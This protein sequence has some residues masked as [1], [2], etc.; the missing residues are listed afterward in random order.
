LLP[1][2]DYYPLRQ[3][4]ISISH[5]RWFAAPFP[6]NTLAIFTVASLVITSCLVPLGIIDLGPTHVLDA[7]SISLLALSFLFFVQERTAL[8]RILSIAGVASGLAPLFFPV[9]ET[10]ASPEG[11]PIHAHAFIKGHEDPFTLLLIC[12]TAALVSAKPLKSSSKNWIMALGAFSTFLVVANV[13]ILG[14]KVAG[15][16][17]TSELGFAN[18]IRIRSLFCLMTLNFAIGF[19]AF[20]KCQFEGWRQSWVAY[21]VALGVIV[22]TFV[23]CSGQVE[24]ETKNKRA[25]AEA[26]ADAMRAQLHDKIRT[27]SLA[28]RRM[29][30][31]IASDGENDHVRWAK[32]A[33]NYIADNPEFKTI[34]WLDKDRGIRWIEPQHNHSKEFHRLRASE[35]SQK[36]ALDNAIKKGS[37]TISRPFKMASNGLAFT[38]FVPIVANGRFQGVVAST[39]QI[40]TLMQAIPSTFSHGFSYNITEQ[41]EVIFG[42]QF[43]KASNVQ[44]STMLKD[45]DLYWIVHAMPVVQ[46]SPWQTP[47]SYLIIAIGF[48]VAT[49]T[50]LSLSFLEKTS[51]YIKEEEKGRRFL[52]GLSDTSVTPT[53]VYDLKQRRMTYANRFGRETLG[54]SEKEILEG[55]LQLLKTLVH[56]DDWAKTLAHFLDVKKLKDRE[57]IVFEHRMKNAAGHWRWYFYQECVLER[58]PNGEVT[59]VL[60]TSTDFTEKKESESALANAK[61]NLERIIENAP[62]GMAIVGT[63]GQWLDVNPALCKILGY[64]KEELLELDF[65]SITHPADLDRDLKNANRILTGEVDSYSVEKRYFHKNGTLV[66][67]HL[68]ASLIRNSE[69]QPSQFVSQIQD[70][71]ERKIHDILN[72][73]FTESLVQQSQVLAESNH[74]LEVESRTDGLTGI[75]NRRYFNEQLAQFLSVAKRYHLPLSVIMLDV[76]HFKKFN[77]EFGHKAGDIV[78]QHVAVVLREICRES[79]I[80]ARYGGEEFVILCP[81]TNSKG[82]MELAQRV[83]QKIHEIELPY[84]KITASLGVASIGISP[85]TIVERADAALYV[86]KEAGRNC[87]T[88]DES[89]DFDR[90]SA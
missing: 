47:F 16:E 18:F 89:K 14:S 75:A 3:L 12:I 79:D 26:N 6:V 9:H 8:C 29:A 35:P 20:K 22:G 1:Q 39:C 86:S 48:I 58:S 5:S 36:Q 34:E 25:E 74:K 61:Q 33:A 41:G 56:P 73:E 21:P 19:V 82:A 11:F 24:F 50:F 55:G 62:I 51:F 70:I 23:L 2:P 87:V 65:Q 31:R 44:G 77:D 53:Y 83:R 72:E 71:T 28:F 60:M 32:D 88:I 63:N 27:H 57:M 78:L 30:T 15:I 66:W 7:L 17:L 37:L 10:I 64:T 40:D 85:E 69:G 13:A 68:R 42:R 81:E 45:W 43:P 59:K 52:E 54:L 76:D 67:V 46:R 4:K 38:I 90:R 80:P 84:R 49:L